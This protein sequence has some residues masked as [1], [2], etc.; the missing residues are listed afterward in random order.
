MTTE[1][2]QELISEQNK[3]EADELEATEK[4]DEKKE[5]AKKKKEE[6]AVK[7]ARKREKAVEKE[8]KELEDA[9]AR[10]IKAVARMEKAA[11][12][13]IT[14]SRGKGRGMGRGGSRGGTHKSM[15]PKWDS[16][17]FVDFVEAPDGVDGVFT[18]PMLVPKGGRDSR[19][20][21]RGVFVPSLE[22][23][24]EDESSTKNSSEDP[25][26]SKCESRFPPANSVSTSDDDEGIQLQPVITPPVGLSTTSN[27][28]TSTVPAPPE[29]AVVHSR[30]GRPIR[31]RVR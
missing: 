13:A 25:P 29:P 4:R 14:K 7:E 20:V 8:R 19:R 31:A 21:Q 24:N 5:A 17:E 12:A 1:V 30:S 2:L 16:V 3:K 15:A 11:Q 9:E 28:A 26:N 10:Q 22:S 18:P 6:A 23:L 27:S